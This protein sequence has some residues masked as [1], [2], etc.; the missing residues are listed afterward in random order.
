MEKAMDCRKTG[1]RRNEYVLC[2]SVAD[3]SPVFSRRGEYYPNAE[4]TC[5]LGMITRLSGRIT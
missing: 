3:E 1:L 5:C 2:K 4:T